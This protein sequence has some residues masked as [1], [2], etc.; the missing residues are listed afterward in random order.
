MAAACTSSQKYRLAPAE[1]PEPLHWFKW[2]AYTTWL[3]GFALMVA[4]YYFDA[5]V[6]LVDPDDCGSVR[7][8]CDRALGRRARARL[9]RVRPA[10]PNGGAAEPGR[11][12]DRRG[13]TGGAGGLGCG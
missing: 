7:L 6:R 1:M 4:L 11:V 10:L 5:G 12:G 3:S 8:V 9:A 2:E 13:S